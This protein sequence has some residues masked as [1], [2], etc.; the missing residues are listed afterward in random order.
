[1]E[2]AKVTEEDTSVTQRGNL[3]AT[4]DSTRPLIAVNI[5]T[6]K[7]D[8]LKTFLCAS[9]VLRFFGSKVQVFV[10]NDAKFPIG[11]STRQRLENLGCIVEDTFFDRNTNLRG[12]STMI[13][14]TGNYIK[15]FNI[16]GAKYLAKIDPD[17]LIISDN[18]SFLNGNSVFG[19]SKNQKPYGNI[20][21]MNSKVVSFLEE[22]LAGDFEKRLLQELRVKKIPKDQYF[23]DFEDLTF[24]FICVLFFGAD[25]VEAKQIHEYWFPAT[26]N[27]L[28]SLL[29]KR[30]DNLVVNFSRQKFWKDGGASLMKQTLRRLS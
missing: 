6:Y 9:S 25:S 21:F 13:G 1:M 4:T 22:L 12:L 2:S 10:W 24:Y 19:F 14:M 27:N 23:M 29:E 3:E 8:E 5:W 30:K 18:L 28:N 11:K 15:S 17:C 20:Y 16:S 26:E 7:G